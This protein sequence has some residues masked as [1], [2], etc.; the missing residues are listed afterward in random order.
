MLLDRWRC[1][2]AA[3]LIALAPHAPALLAGDAPAGLGERLDDALRTAPREAQVGLVVLDAA[4]GSVWFARN[5]H[6]PLKPASVMK[7]FVTA[8]AL[9]R[10]G[11][12]FTFETK[13]YMHDRELWVI[14][15]GDPGLADVRIATR[16][17]GDWADVLDTWTAAIR[18]RGVTSFDKLVLD[19]SVFDEE[20]RHPDWDPGQADAWYQAPVGGLNICDNCVEIRVS[21][22]GATVRTYVAPPLP[23]E[24][25]RSTVIA[26]QKHRPILK[27]PA[28]GDVFELQGTVARDCVVGPASAGRPTVFFGHVLKHALQ[29]RG[30]KVTGD[31]VRRKL[32]AEHV[33]VATHVATHRT[34][35]RDCLWRS[36]TFSQ[37]LFAECL[38]KSLAAYGPE[39]RRT[40]TPGSWPAGTEIVRKTVTSLGVNMAGAVLRD[41]SGLSHDN[42]VTAEQV[43]RLL[44]VMRTHRCCDEFTTSLAEPGKEGTLR[45]RGTAALTGRLRA[46]TGTIAHARALAGY[47]YRQDGTTA[48]FALLVNGPSPSGFPIRIATMIAK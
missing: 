27:R 29:T 20:H 28:A 5:E 43:A 7:L 11:P 24:F 46:K 15:G 40:G 2:L 21:I 33:G 10:L 9:E 44:L 31:V 1:V 47:V 42:R 32:T 26:G 16:R 39:G 36:N 13:L 30:I 45:K 6:T 37:N 41:G 17:G 3:L 23:A 34:S 18:A 12:E 25:L 4:D 48:V 38:L 8:S 35:M 19:D 14:G 22:S